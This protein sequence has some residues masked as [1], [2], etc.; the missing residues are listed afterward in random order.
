MIPLI[1]I[2]EKIEQPEGK[3]KIKLQL[4]L[5]DKLNTSSEAGNLTKLEMSLN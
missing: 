5:Q 4:D 1:K 2:P 3:D